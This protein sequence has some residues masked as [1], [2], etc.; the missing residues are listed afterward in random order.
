MAFV[1][2]KGLALYGENNCLNARAKWRIIKKSKSHIFTWEKKINLF[3]VSLT[4]YTDCA[5][6]TDLVML[7]LICLKMM[8][9]SFTLL[10]VVKLKTSQDNH[11]M[12]NFGLFFSSK[13]AEFLHVLSDLIESHSPVFFYA[14]L[15]F[16]FRLKRMQK[17]SAALFAVCCWMTSKRNLLFSRTIKSAKRPVAACFLHTFLLEAV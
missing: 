11:S 5:W 2:F 1:T 6:T 8:Y 17:N 9:H 3:D 4:N 10:E 16:V 13:R 15:R 12:S 14:G 7:F